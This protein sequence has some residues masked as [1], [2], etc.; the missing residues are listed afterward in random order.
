MHEEK[1]F[2]ERLKEAVF[3]AQAVLNKAAQQGKKTT[4]PPTPAPGSPSLA[5]IVKKRQAEGTL[6][7]SNPL[8]DTMKKSK[9]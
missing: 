6:K 9:K 7:P 1:S 5:D 8:L 2:I 4:T 3:P